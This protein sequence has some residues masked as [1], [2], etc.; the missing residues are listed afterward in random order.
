MTIKKQAGPRR[1]LY[2]AWA[3]FF[4]GAERALVRALRALETTPYEP[5]VLVGTD[6]ELAAQLR[7]L[8]IPHRITPIVPLDR[9]RPIEALR[10][11]AG[12]IR[13]IQRF[14]PAVIHANDVPS[15]QPGGYAAR[16]AGRPA[17]THVRFPDTAKGYRWFLRSGFTRAIF[18]S[19]DQRRTA[20]TEAPDLF[21]GRSEVL[22]DC[23]EVQETWTH[24]QRRRIRIELGVPEDCVLVAIVGQIAEVKG[25]WDFVEAARLLIENGSTAHFVVL[26]DDLKSGGVVRTAMRQKVVANGAEHRFTFLGFHPDAAKLVQAFDIVAVPSHVEPFGLAALE[27]SASGRAVVASLVGGLPE[28]VIGGETGLLIQPMDPRALANSLD[29][30]IQNANLRTTLGAAARRRARDSFGMDAY[31]ARLSA[32]Y[33]ALGAAGPLYRSQV[34]ATAI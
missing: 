31:G 10:S 3:P 24:D 14:R 9:H 15:F 17:L 22:H 29:R 19:E 4:S 6:G 18:V 2:L 23:V 32:I 20:V 1:V 33:D 28:I 11:L 16:L 7:N 12:V 8:R 30:L 27:G 13:A 34:E 21:D 26:G 5:Y 25:I